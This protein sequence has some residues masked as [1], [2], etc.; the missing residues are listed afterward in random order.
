MNVNEESRMCHVT[1][2]YGF[3]NRNDCNLSWN[4]L[5]SLVPANGL[6]WLCKGDFN[7]LLN[8]DDKKGRV[9]HPNGL[10]QGFRNATLIVI[11]GTFLL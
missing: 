4:L 11:L 2:Y 5:R 9:D 8:S 10:Y 7:D 3:P 6:P 1:G